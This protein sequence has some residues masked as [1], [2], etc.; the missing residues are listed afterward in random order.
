MKA[1]ILDAAR[2]VLVRHGLP[3]WTVEKIA[4]TAGCAK[5]L[6]IYYF[7]GRDALLEQ[8]AGIVRED[9]QRLRIEALSVGGTRALDELWEALRNEVQSGDFGAWLGLTAL[10]PGAVRHAASSTSAE[11]AALGAAAAHALDLSRDPGG[12]LL[13]ATLSGYQMA[14]HARQDEATVREAYH[15][16]W[17][18]LLEE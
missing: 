1:A 18:S 5:G 2:A 3:D 17:L 13:D 10:P 8:V 16:F 6:V 4:E 14:L 9:R 7:R 12:I 11:L 15:R